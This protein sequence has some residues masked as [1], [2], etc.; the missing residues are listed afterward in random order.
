MNLGGSP[1]YISTLSSPISILSPAKNE[2]LKLTCS[3]QKNLFAKWP[4]TLLVQV[5]EK[6]AVLRFGGSN[7]ENVVSNIIIH[8]FTINSRVRCRGVGCSQTHLLV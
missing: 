7:Q 5:E 8:Y 3:K 1:P 2:M 4:L 6:Y